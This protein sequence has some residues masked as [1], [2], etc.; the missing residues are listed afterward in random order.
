MNEMYISHVT[1][2]ESNLGTTPFQN[3][4]CIANDKGHLEAKSRKTNLG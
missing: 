2:E 3:D 1:S 4:C